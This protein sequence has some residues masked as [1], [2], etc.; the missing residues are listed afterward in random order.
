MRLNFKARVF[1]KSQTVKG[2]YVIQR[3]FKLGKDSICSFVL[4][5]LMNDFLTEKEIC[6]TFTNF[7]FVFIGKGLPAVLSVVD[8]EI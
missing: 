2:S 1:L 5:V 4:L 3:S 7:Y 8:V 6:S